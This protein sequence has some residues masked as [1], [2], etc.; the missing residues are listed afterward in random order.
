MGW[1]RL[2]VFVPNRHWNWQ[3]KEWQHRMNLFRRRTIPAGSLVHESAYLRGAEYA[4]H[5]P[6]GAI[7]VPIRRQPETGPPT[8]N[9][10]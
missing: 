4:Q 7:P 5:I 8:K 2:A 6:P 1:W 9:I 3:T 10:S